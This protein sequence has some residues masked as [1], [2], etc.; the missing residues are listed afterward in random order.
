MVNGQESIQT[1]RPDQTESP[2]IT[3]K[4]HLQIETGVFYEKTDRDSENF[5]YPTLLWK[6]GINENFELR[7]ITEFNSEKM[8]SNRNAG[9]SPLSLGFKT[10]LSEEKKYVPKISFMGHLTVNKLASESFKTTY[11]APS[12]RFVFQH[13]LSDKINLGYNVGAE[14]NGETPDATGIYTIATSYSFTEKLG[15]F[16]EIYG[17]INRYHK[18]DH[19]FDAG[20][21]YL[22]TD[23]LQMDASSGIGLSEISPAYFL[24][25]GVSYRFRTH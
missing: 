5:S 18:P 9:V 22:L 17:V 12:F 11:P 1:D 19:R 20:F 3:P 24:S 14:W 25:F 15:G 23:D 7:M 16:A 2:A 21:T 13:T 4:N 10:R 6:Y 8:G